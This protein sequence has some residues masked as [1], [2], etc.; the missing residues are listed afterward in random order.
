MAK[1]EI[2]NLEQMLNKAK[3]AAA[4]GEGS[5]AH[6]QE[7]MRQQAS[8]L[9]D[10]L[11]TSDDSNKVLLASFSN[12]SKEILSII[13]S[14]TEK[15]VGATGKEARQLSRQLKDLQRL[16]SDVSASERRVIEDR[17]KTIRQG[18]ASGGGS[19]LGNVISDRLEKF[20]P[21]NI[22]K[23]LPGPLGSIG[24]FLG[25]V[26]KQSNALKITNLE[27]A[28]QVTQAGLN[29]SAGSTNQAGVEPSEVAGAMTSMETTLVRIS[30]TLDQIGILIGDKIAPEG[31]TEDQREFF[32]AGTTRGSLFTHDEHVTDQ[33]KESNSLLQKVVKLLTKDKLQGAEDR[34]EA[35]RS[36]G[37][38]GRQ[39]QFAF[40][41]DGSN[42]SGFPTSSPGFWANFLTAAR[43]V[44]MN[45]YVAGTAGFL[46]L[47]ALNRRFR[48]P[49]VNMSVDSAGRMRF[50]EPGGNRAL[51]YSDPRVQ[52]WMKQNGIDPSGAVSPNR[53][54]QSQQATRGP[55]MRYRPRMRNIL[56]LLIPAGG[57][58]GIGYG[59]SY[60]DSSIA[61]GDPN[62]PMSGLGMVDVSN[63]STAVQMAQYMLGQG[64]D[65]E[66]V[67]SL[68]R[69]SGVPRGMY[70]VE[71]DLAVAMR[72]QMIAEGM[73]PEQ[74]EAA[75]REQGLFQS[76]QLGQPGMFGL[77]EEMGGMGVEGGMVDAGI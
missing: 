27:N 11:K 57:A 1:R 56:G 40:M 16:S 45:P 4:A 38:L 24:N 28:L 39:G 34:A 62:N 19:A 35:A 15:M 41:G 6:R 17:I 49:G 9:L 26:Q 61:G 2:D 36:M 46:G 73:S 64:M 71:E 42:P 20:Q 66:T 33:V 32:K 58:A 22:L 72:Q 67:H 5:A 51:P 23:S 48:G 7:V 53:Q 29:P 52:T 18:A 59:A 12:K 8:S 77:P 14:T 55:R 10:Y 37:R 54:F 3:L 76:S 47:R 43:G 21:I 60:L 44:A 25:D 74:T 70:Q 69:V 75:L 65:I 31:L 63:T 13:Q 30:Q 50:T 68:L